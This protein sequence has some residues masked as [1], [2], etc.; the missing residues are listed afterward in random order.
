MQIALVHD[1]LTQQGG[2]ENVFRVFTEIFPNAPIY[3]FF[4]DGKKFKDVLKDRKVYS[5]FLQKIPGITKHYRWTLPFMPK[6]TESFD[7][8]DYNVVLSSTSAFAKGIVA[9]PKTL[10]ICYCHTPTRYLWIDSDEYVRELKYNRLVK[11]AIPY[12]LENLRQWDKKAALRVGKYLTNS[13]EVQKRIKKYYNRDAKVIYPP[14][15]IKNYYL[16]H[17]VELDPSKGYYLIGGRL[18]AYKRYDLAITAFN[19]MGIKLK[20]FGDGPEEARLKQMAK[21]N[22]EFLG[23]VSEEE[24]RKL[25]AN[26]IAFIH[27]QVEDFGITPIETMA[28]GRPVIA[29]SAGGVLETV[30]N[31]TTGKFFPEQTWES[32]AETVIRFKPENFDTQR[33]RQQAER[34]GVERFKEEIRDFIKK[35]TNLSEK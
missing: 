11:K 32:L 8:S 20:I 12:L 27:P 19:R 15:D 9:G 24:K 2:A 31:N 30:V 34:F 35:C 4:Y 23:R 33:I 28:A 16:S 22:I 14:V 17:N 3:T 25:F 13:I 10:H 21:P 29:Y 1:Y 5:S 26:C 6:L 18:V 7:F